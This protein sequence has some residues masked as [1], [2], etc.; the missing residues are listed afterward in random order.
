MEW[1]IDWRYTFEAFS[2][3]DHGITYKVIPEHRQNL[4]YISHAE[5]RMQEYK[6]AVETFG[7][8]SITFLVTYSTYIAYINVAGGFI[9]FEERRRSRRSDITV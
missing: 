1:L 9:T 6:G 5:N 2:H 8:Y 7:Y 4:L 3:I